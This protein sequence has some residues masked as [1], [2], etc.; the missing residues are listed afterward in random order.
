MKRRDF[1][2]STTLTA[3]SASIAAAPLT[4]LAET[5]VT[6]LE[7]EDLSAMGPDPNGFPVNF[8]AIGDWGR[9]G[10][11][12][13]LE[14]AKT[15]GDWAR[16]NPVDFIVSVGD[17]FYPKGV[18][19]ENDP[20]WHYSFENVYTAHSLQIDWFAILGNHD[21]YSEPDAQIRYGKVSRRWHM[22]S[23]YY[24]KE[25]AIG[26]TKAKA[27]FVMIDSQAI[28]QDY[29]DQHPEKQLAWIEKTLQDASDD[30]KWKIVVGH[31]PTYTVGPRINNYDTLAIR[32]RLGPILEKQKVDLY[33]SGHEHSMQHL[34]PQGYTHQFISGAGS[35]LTHVTEGIAMSRFQAS[36]NG[37]MYFSIDE[38]RL[39][40][41]VI[42]VTGKT[43]Y[44]T[45]L[46][47]A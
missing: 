32:E 31:H 9:N 28:V 8:L 34:K 40:V 14:T 30:V 26:K 7:S 27:L 10:E 25:V 44:N 4:T 6:H 16:V 36:E 42:S 43:L 13:Q 46:N 15:M 37:F 41:K 29:K 33:L 47:K 17:N 2:R 39:N 5:Q 45:Q 1:V 38:K 21:Y 3:L 22:P 35:E 20:L 18:V 19:S 24:T 12:L 23:R 11:N